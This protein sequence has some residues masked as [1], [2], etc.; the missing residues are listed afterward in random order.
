MRKP[1][2]LLAAMVEMG[3]MVDETTAL[4]LLAL[5]LAVFGITRRLLHR[6]HQ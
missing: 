4:L 6:P 2:I 3:P 5:G 1:P